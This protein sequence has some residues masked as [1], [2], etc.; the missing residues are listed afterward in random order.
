[1]I[2]ALRSS[3]F[4]RVGSVT[5]L[6]VDTSAYPVKRGNCFSVQIDDAE[7]KVINFNHENLMFLIQLGLKLPVE[8]LVD[9]ETKRAFIHDTRIKDKWYDKDVCEIC[10][11]MKFWSAAQLLRR[12]RDID[13]GHLTVT[14]IR[15]TI[16]G[17]EKIWEVES[18]QIPYWTDIPQDCMVGMPRL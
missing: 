6:G 17:V 18:R 7:Y 15:M 2:Q 13:A 3:K 5:L 12:Q 14:P 1:M 9:D 4:S 16:D 10:S 8:I 11:P